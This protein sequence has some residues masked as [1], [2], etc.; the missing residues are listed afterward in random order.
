MVLGNHERS[1]SFDDGKIKEIEYLG[2]V[3][4]ALDSLR[5]LAVII[6]AD[7]ES[8]TKPKL[9]LVTN[10]GT[11]VCSTRKVRKEVLNR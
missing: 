5:L 11:K 3:V 2:V 10:L 6:S 1:S 9:V 8:N 4:G 7:I